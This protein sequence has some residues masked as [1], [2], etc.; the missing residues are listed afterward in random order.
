MALRSDIQMGYA[1][2][3]SWGQRWWKMRVCEGTLY[4]ARI[5][6][7][8]LFQRLGQGSFLSY[9]PLHRQH[10]ELDKVGDLV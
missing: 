4:W 1:W 9:G 10:V 6:V 8:V 5:K 3:E 7:N 2:I